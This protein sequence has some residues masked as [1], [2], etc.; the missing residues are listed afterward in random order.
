M[1]AHDKVSLLL[2]NKA[3]LEEALPF[4]HRFHEFQFLLP[5]PR[6]TVLTNS[7]GLPYRIE[8]ILREIAKVR[9]VDLG[10]ELGNPCSVNLILTVELL[11]NACPNL[12]SI[13]ADIVVFPG[14]PKPYEVPVLEELWHRLNH[15]ELVIRYLNSCDTDT[16]L[17]SI[18]PGLKWSCYETA[19]QRAKIFY[20]GKKRT[21]WKKVF[22]IDRAHLVEGVTEID[23]ESPPTSDDDASIDSGDDASVDS[24]DDESIDSS[25]DESIDSGD[26][27]SNS[28][29]SG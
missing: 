9:L 28:G 13:M 6:E 27:E 1:T 20:D 14:N 2:A 15:L 21:C 24:G 18:V 8:P 11:Y 10:T 17:K 4:L 25:D 7:F 3:V 5:D 23:D 12:K 22:F 16:Y 29:D 19:E 26:D